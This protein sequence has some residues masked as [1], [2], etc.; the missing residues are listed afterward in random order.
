M[1]Y[2]SSME[3]DR[4]FI[5]A[6]GWIEEYYDDK[7]KTMIFVQKGPYHT[8]VKGALLKAKKS[9]AT[10]IEKE[11]EPAHKPSGTIIEPLNE[12]NDSPET[13]S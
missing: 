5:I 2:N 4:G 3:K 1:I 10:W 8:T 9:G 7:S 11:G 12:G 13:S 6:R